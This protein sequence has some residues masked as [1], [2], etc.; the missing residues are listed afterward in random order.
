MNRPINA[1]FANSNLESLES[2]RSV[3][4]RSVKIIFRIR[5]T[6]LDISGNNGRLEGKVLTVLCVKDTRIIQNQSCTLNARSVI[7]LLV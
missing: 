1:V 7:Y 3:D 2:A 5:F 6:V 4:M